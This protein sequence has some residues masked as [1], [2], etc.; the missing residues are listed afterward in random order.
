[1]KKKNWR[2]ILGVVPLLIIVVQLHGQELE[3]RKIL[4]ET[5]EISLPKEFK[6]LSADVIAKKYPSN[7]R[8]A[9]VYGNSSATLNLAHWRSFAH[10]GKGAHLWRV[11]ILSSSCTA[12]N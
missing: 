7:N 4:S 11:S 3:Q 8:P 9:L 2:R 6:Q 1:M 5:I 10:C 12:V